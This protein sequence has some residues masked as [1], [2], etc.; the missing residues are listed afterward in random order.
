MLWEIFQENNKI[1]FCLDLL[2]ELLPVLLCPCVRSSCREYTLVL[3]K[4][5][6]TNSE[7]VEGTLNETGQWSGGH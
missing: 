7:S 1:G 2:S 6:Q 5:V 4:S 3:E